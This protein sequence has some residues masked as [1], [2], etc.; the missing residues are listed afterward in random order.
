MQGQVKGEQ[1]LKPFFENQ[2]KKVLI[3]GRRANGI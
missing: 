2:K 3:S 1:I